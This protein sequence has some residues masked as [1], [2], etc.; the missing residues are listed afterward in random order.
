MAYLGFD[1]DAARE[2]RILDLRSNAAGFAAA[3]VRKS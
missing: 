2:Q 3:V 1:V